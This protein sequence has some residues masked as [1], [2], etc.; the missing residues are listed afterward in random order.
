MLRL[1]PISLREANRF[2]EERHRHHGPKQGHKFAISVY[3]EAALVGVA[4]VGRPDARK[5]DHRL[6]AEVTRLCTDGT[7]NACT[8][9]YG[10]S[11]RAAKAMGYEWIRTAILESES[12]HSLK[13]AG[14]KYSHTTKAQEWS[15][16]SRKRKP[17]A[18]AE[19]PKK[20]YVKELS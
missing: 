13:A 18:H 5:V 8:I 10:A 1:R 20:I 9:L 14:W 11:A 2:V 3:L 4:I 6:W 12:G 15:R 7:H 19:V 16:P 17:V